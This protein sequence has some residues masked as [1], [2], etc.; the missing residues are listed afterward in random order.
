MSEA[1]EPGAVPADAGR[2]SA[3]LAELHAVLRKWRTEREEILA[4]GRELARAVGLAAP[5]AQDSMS[6]LHAQATKQSLG[7]LQR[8][9]DALLQQ[10]D[11]YIEKLAAALQD[12]QQGEED[13]AE[14]FRRI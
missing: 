2:S 9:N 6:V 13:A 1:G 3:D 11:S 4:D 8:H 12:M 7:E 10:V 5:P 14:E